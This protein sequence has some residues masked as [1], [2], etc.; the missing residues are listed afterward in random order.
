[1]CHR[2][3]LVH[4]GITNAVLAG[5]WS[6]VACCSVLTRASAG[7]AMRCGGLALA[8]LV[9]GCSSQPRQSYAD[10]VLSRPLPAS[11]AERQSECTWVRGEIARQTSLAEVGSTTAN[12]PMMAMVFQ[13]TARNNIAALNSRASNIQCNAAFSN[14]PAAP[15]YGQTFDQCFARCQQLTDRTK[16]QCF[17]A[18]NH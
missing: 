7:A 16:N 6:S 5:R 1:M 8:L 13:A 3:T 12:P 10:A 15:S 2:V 14:A 17:D 18:C 9:V 4:N 11:D